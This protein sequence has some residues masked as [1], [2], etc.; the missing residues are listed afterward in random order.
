[1]KKNQYQRNN[2]DAILH[3]SSATNVESIIIMRKSLAE[4]K[5]ILASSQSDKQK[6]EKDL[7]NL[8]IRYENLLKDK[9]YLEE[10]LFR[11]KEKTT[12]IK[13]LENVIFENE[14]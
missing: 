2:M 8:S 11:Y 5:Q 4:M 1:M 9:K 13:N 10:D 7:A 14:N 3:E 6:L 12:E